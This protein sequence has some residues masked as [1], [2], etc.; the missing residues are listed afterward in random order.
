VIRERFNEALIFF[1]V[2]CVAGTLLEWLYGNFWNLVGTSPWVYPGS[3]LGF[4][5]LEV[6][7]LWGMG[8]LICMALYKA[9]NR[10]LAK[11]LYLVGIAVVLAALY[12]VLVAIL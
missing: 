1:I 6:V 9:I 7:P 4:T 11:E 10:R 3:S 5:S 8:G 12:I 2:A